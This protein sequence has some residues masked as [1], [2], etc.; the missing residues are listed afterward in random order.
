MSCIGWRT[1]RTWS[2]AVAAT[3]AEIVELYKR[4]QELQAWGPSGRALLREYGLWAR[5]QGSGYRGAVDKEFTTGSVRFNAR[6]LVLT[7]SPSNSSSTYVT[8]LWIMTQAVRGLEGSEK[9]ERRPG[10]TR[11]PTMALHSREDTWTKRLFELAFLEALYGPA[12]AAQMVADCSSPLYT[13]WKRTWVAMLEEAERLY[14]E[15]VR[16]RCR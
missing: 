11:R 6:R 15:E 7:M 13:Y 10:R 4:W 5:W 9:A 8:L 1:F 2:R 16:R 3:R 12:E 14:R